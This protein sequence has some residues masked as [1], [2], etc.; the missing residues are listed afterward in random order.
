M[1]IIFHDEE[2]IKGKFLRLSQEI[3]FLGSLKGFCYVYHFRK[4]FVSGTYEDKSCY[5]HKSFLFYYT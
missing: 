5:S 4:D 2:P 1:I 3:N